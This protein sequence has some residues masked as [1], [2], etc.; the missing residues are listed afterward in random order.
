MDFT[1]PNRTV[2]E[3]MYQAVVRTT[4]PHLKGSIPTAPPIVPGALVDRL[5]ELA[6]LR[7]VVSSPAR[8]VPDIGL[9][10]AQPESAVFGPDGA[11][12]VAVEFSPAPRATGLAR[13]PDV[14]ATA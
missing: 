3:V 14:R 6:V 8:P 4:Q 2:D 10:A 13:L 12:A 9:G 11:G 5:A 7:P 1:I